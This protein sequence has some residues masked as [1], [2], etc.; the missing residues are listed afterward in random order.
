MVSL[1]PNKGN[2]GTKDE[3]LQQAEQIWS[4]LDEMVD[5]DPTAY[6]NFIENQMKDAHKFI[7]EKG[8]MLE[9]GLNVK[10]RDEE[11]YL[12]VEIYS[13]VLVPSPN[14]N[15]SIA[16]LPLFIQPEQSSWC[17]NSLYQ[18]YKID[19]ISPFFAPW[20]DGFA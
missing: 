5:S 15:G 6:K 14:L 18:T 13:S 19:Y 20:S 3:V 11:G 10:L 2:F 4:M 17:S 7:E 1:L 12:F 9:F 16:N 8:T